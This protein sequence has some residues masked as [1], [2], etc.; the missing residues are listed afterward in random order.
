MS[1]WKVAVLAMLAGALGAVGVVMVF[2]EIMT[3]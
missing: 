3:W 1:D 2:V